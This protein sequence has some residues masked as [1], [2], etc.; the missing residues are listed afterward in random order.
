MT[1]LPL[2][3]DS[4][5]PELVGQITSHGVCV[6]K[7]PTGAGKTTRVPG[8]V[9]DANPGGGRVILVEPRRLAARTAAKRIAEERGVRLGGEVGYRVRFDDRSQASTRILCVTE[10]ILLRMLQDDPFLEGVGCILFDEFHERSLAIDLA[11]AMAR[12]VREETRPDLALVV[13][14]ATIEVKPIANWLNDAPVV[15]SPGRLFPVEAHYLTPSEAALRER[16]SL[17]TLLRTKIV[18]ALET[19]EGHVLVFLPGVPEIRRL[20]QTLEGLRSRFNVEL[21]ELFGDLSPG[22]QDRVLAPGKRRKLILATNVAETSIT[23]EG[24][25]AVVD[26]GLVKRLYHEPGVGLDRLRTER[27]SRASAGQRKGRAGRTGPG[28]CYRLWTEQDDRTFEERERPEIAR[29]DLA[30]CV[31]ELAAWGETKPEEFPWFEAPPEKAL[32]RAHE[33]LVL[34]GAIRENGTPTQL[35]QELARLPVH[36]RLARLIHEGRQL[37]AP[38]SAALAA[39][40]LSERDPFRREPRGGARE[41]S[42]SD[43]SARVHALD[44]FEYSGELRSGTGELLRGAAKSVLRVRDQLL[45]MIRADRDAEC[46]AEDEALLA[47]AILAAFPDRVCRRRANDAERAVMVGGSG[48]RLASECSVREA[49]LFCAVETRTG[50]GESLVRIASAI[51]ESWLDDAFVERGARLTWDEQEERVVAAEQTSYRDLVLRSTGI[52]VS[53]AAGAAALL[54]QEAAKNIHSALNLKSKEAAT[55]LARVRLLREACPELELPAFDEAHLA[56]LLPDMCTRKRSFEE[57]RK[58]NLASFLSSRLDY[59]VTEALRTEAPEALA[60]PS[61]NKIRLTYADGQTP[62]LAVRIQEMFGLAETPRIAKGRVPVL[63]HLL[64]PNMRPQ[65]VTDDLR[66]FWNGA[67]AVVRKELRRRYPKHAWPEDPWNAQP[68]R[69]PRRRRDR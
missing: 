13:M 21:L 56:T 42:D 16:D 55:F 22:E 46:R 39:A 27:I 4:V 47:R 12:R 66:S 36:P 34:L 59:K 25:S 18:S 51:E 1:L 26:S 49:E 69:G 58:M 40:L 14:S 3:I 60:V 5:L 35:G 19:T 63:L 50:G 37:G 11:L 31:L 6:L 38:A 52:A 15:E 57:L 32:M 29:V 48:V 43:V 20:A 44:E 9:L 64:A 24:I 17:Q 30:S 62:V 7:A 54:E 68:M 61:G 33:L 10:G 67:Y 65:Q 8:A 45:R 53:D 28:V 41:W 23:I 2:P